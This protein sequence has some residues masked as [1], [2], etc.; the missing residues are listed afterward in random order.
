MRQFGYVRPDSVA[1]ALELGAEPGS[2]YL[3]GGTNL[4]DLMKLGVE[5]PEL[6][7]DISS[8]VDSGIAPS[9]DG[10]LLIGGGAGNA[11]VA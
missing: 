5:V 2:R 4:V 3:A 6:L 11:E 8:V 7:V 1:E 10:G 9:A